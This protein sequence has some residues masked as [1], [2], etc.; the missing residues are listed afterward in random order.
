VVFQAFCEVPPILN[1]AIG[2]RD[3]KQQRAFADNFVVDLGSWYFDV[4]HGI[5]NADLVVS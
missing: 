3:T 2:A 1:R 4:R 5:G